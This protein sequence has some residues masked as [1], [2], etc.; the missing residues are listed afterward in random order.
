MKGVNGKI[1][2]VDLSRQDYTVDEHGDKF[3]RKYVGG[4][5]IALYYMHKELDP[6]V[7]PYSPDNMLVFA[8]SIL[9]GAQ[10]PAIPRLTVCGK[11]PLTGGFGESEAGGFWAPEL[12]QAG[13][14]AVVVTGKAESPVYLWI[15]NGE[16]E[17]RDACKLWGKV[18]GE[19]QETIRED[20]GDERIHVAQIGPGAE[21][22]V[23]YGN[24]TN[25][26][27]HFNGRCGL[28]AVMGSKNLKALAVRGTQGIELANKDEVM[29]LNRWVAKEGM[30][31]PV[32]ARLHESGT[33]SATRGNQEAG[34]LPTK[35]WHKSQFDG[36]DDI[37]DESWQES[38]A[39]EGR[40]CFACP[41]RC[42]RVVEVDEDDIQV[43]PAYGGPEYETVGAIGSLLEVDSKKVIA[44]ANELCNKYTIDTI[45]TGMSIA[46]AMD[47]YENDL[48][49]REDCDGLELEFGNEDVVLPMIKKIA[50]REGIGDL[51][52]EGTMVAAQKIGQ[53]AEKYVH[54]V[55]GQEAPMHDPRVKTGVGM[56]YALSNYGADHMKAPHDTDFAR[57]DSY[58]LQSLKPI[59]LY[60][61]VDPLAIDSEKVRL[62]YNLELYWTLIDITG[63]CCFGYVPSGPV[64]IEKML[65]LIKAVTG[66]YI[67]LRELMDA[68]ERS[69]DMARVFNNKI[70]FTPE[71]DKLPDKFFEN[72]AD[73]PHEGEG[74]ID[75]ED[76]REAVE[77]YYEM[78]GW[79]PK[80]AKP[81]KAKLV[82]MGID[83]IRKD[84]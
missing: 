13:F 14:D 8:G 19:V 34:A 28:G 43:D 31:I 75:K 42:K 79:D 10:G 65:D 51:L 70:G 47:C 66:E 49:S 44:K 48:L 83:W 63:C 1:L 81:K 38:Y 53:G 15:K 80:T 69:I 35:N 56:Q 84:D 54:H 12:K 61:T 29:E 4:R 41:I 22:Q 39:K 16:V 68:A 74:A 45:S 37:D 21:N 58:G 52:A 9:V 60:D 11:S 3:Y 7:E 5:G 71:D 33:W 2:K 25:K 73:G 30:D 55:K 77:L 23:R 40:G 64:S 82:K 20:L 32:A 6:S 50:N 46:F 24:I 27:G 62:F 26:L 17:F 67:S 36:V 59:G 76:F 57:E 72:F 78:M 18:T